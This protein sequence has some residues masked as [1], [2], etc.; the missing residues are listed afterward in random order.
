MNPNDAPSAGRGPD[1]WFDTSAV[2]DPTPGTFG[3]LG[4]YSNIGPP[5]FNF[6]F[7]LF[8]DFQITEGT[9]VQFR[10]ESFNL[11]NSPQFSNPNST[12]GNSNFGVI[13]GTSGG[14]ARQMQFALRFMF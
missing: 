2:T 9:K 3:N 7:S 4:N 1:L 6:D 14:S 12:Q 8:K 11:W 5:R 13:T 10:A